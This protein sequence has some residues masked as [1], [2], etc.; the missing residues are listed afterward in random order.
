MKKH[1]GG[2]ICVLLILSLTIISWRPVGG[3][4]K[5]AI[6]TNK[7]FSARELLEKYVNTIYESAHLQ[8]SGL[9]FDVFKKAV[10]GFINLKLANKLPQTGSILTIIDFT[11]PSREKRMW[12]VDIL[13]KDL[14]LN[15]W[16]AHGQGSGNDVA[17]NFSDDIESH[18]SSLGFYLTDDIYIGKHGRS[19]RLDG[20]DTGYNSNARARDIVVHAANYVSQREINHQGRLGRSFGCPAVSPKLAERIIKTIRNKTVM[21]IN[22]NDNSYTSRYLNEDMAATF[23]SQDSNNTVVASL[24]TPDDTSGL[25]TL[26]TVVKHP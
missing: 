24:Q 15:T 20:L 16:V 17:T 8:E 7:P 6:K 9:G 2:L 4:E 11:K 19:L 10:T 3:T 5:Q 13:N 22:G 25:G 1:F 18:Q 23:V 21:F 26:D 14:I 12:I